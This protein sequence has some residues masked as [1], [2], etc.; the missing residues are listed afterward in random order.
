MVQ[1]YLSFLVMKA[2]NKAE[3]S[4]SRE[5]ENVVSKLLKN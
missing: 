5:T 2:R 4:A 3:F 1:D